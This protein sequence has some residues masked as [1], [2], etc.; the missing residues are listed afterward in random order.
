MGDLAFYTLTAFPLFRFSQAIQAM[1]AH[2]SQQPKSKYGTKFLNELH[3]ESGFASFHMLQICREL[4][5]L[6][7]RITHLSPVPHPIHAR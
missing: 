2:T 1:L 7:D 4:V 5:V 6:V 3:S